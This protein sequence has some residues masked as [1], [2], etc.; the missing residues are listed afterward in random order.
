L[1]LQYL[2]TRSF[3]LIIKKLKKIK[4]RR[5]YLNTSIPKSLLISLLKVLSV[6]T[7]PKMYGDFTPVTIVITCILP[8][9]SGSTLAPIYTTALGSSCL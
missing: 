1:P 8:S 2:K 6:V 9:Y 5:S 7:L 3:D 4:K